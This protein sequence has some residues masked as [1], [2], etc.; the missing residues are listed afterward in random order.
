M[1]IHITVPNT[2]FPPQ[3][4]QVKLKFYRTSV[5]ENYNVDQVFQYLSELYVKNLRQREAASM[6]QYHNF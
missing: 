1:F 4:C 2:N 3:P 5:Q 6:G